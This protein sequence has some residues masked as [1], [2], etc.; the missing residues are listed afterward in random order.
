M[1][2]LT[3]QG[4]FFTCKYYNGEFISQQ[5]QHKKNTAFLLCFCET[6]QVA[7]L[8][9]LSAVFVKKALTRCWTN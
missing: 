6:Q 3:T 7:V 4:N 5:S 9:L 2:S 8:I 1:Y